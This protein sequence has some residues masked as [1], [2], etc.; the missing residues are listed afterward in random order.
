[1]TGTKT[2]CPSY[3]EYSYGKMTTKLQEPTPAVRLREIDVSLIES[4]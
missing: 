2:R 1:M 3:R 4:I